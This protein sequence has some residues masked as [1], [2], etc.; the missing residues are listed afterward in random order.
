[1]ILIHL[2]RPLIR[3]QRRKPAWPPV[4]APRVA[5]PP[6]FASPLPCSAPVLVE[7]GCAPPK[8]GFV[9]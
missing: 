5:L 6:L 3:L 2:P 9:L 8:S 7:K 1:M 4:L